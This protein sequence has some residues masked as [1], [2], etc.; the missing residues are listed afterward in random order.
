MQSIWRNIRNLTVVALAAAVLCP[1]AWSRTGTR[2]SHV[3][4]MEA[5]AYA[6]TAKLTTDGTVAHEGIAAADPLIV[7]LNSRIRVT[8]AGPYS[9]I[10]NVRDTGEKIAGRRIDLCLPTAAAAKRFGKKAVTVR[11]LKIGNNRPVTEAGAKVIK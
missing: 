6:P 1:A 11:V 7:P 8:G 5:T 10:Y 9:G 4:R 2:R 3:M